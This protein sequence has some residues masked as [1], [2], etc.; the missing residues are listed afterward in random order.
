MDEHGL[1]GYNAGAETGRLHRGLGLIEFAR[2]KELLMACLPPAPAVVYDIGGAYGEYAFWLA[3]MGYEVHLFDLAEGHIR[4]ARVHDAEAAEPH[5]LAAAE[6]ADARNVPRPD[7]SADA[8]LLLGPLYHLPEKADREAALAECRRLLKP[9]GILVTAHIVPWA[10]L[11]DNVIHY[12]E[13]PRLDDDTV[14]HRLAD[15]VRTGRH[16]GKVVGL[17]YFSRPEDTRREVAA[18]GF[19]DVTLHGVL[20]PCWTIRNLDEA[21]TDER[22]R[23]AILRVVRLLDREESLMGFSTHYVTISRKGCEP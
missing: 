19:V 20:G 14:Y 4:T 1:A 9:G 23:E 18:A 22:S 6:V 13:E 15:T 17:M 11:V 12:D 16:R 3:E 10:P 21:W 8:V 2:T 7:A 5:R